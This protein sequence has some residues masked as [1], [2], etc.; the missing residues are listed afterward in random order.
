MKLKKRVALSLAAAFSLLVILL[1]IFFWL[2]LQPTSSSE[3]KIFVINKGERL[4]SIA[5][6]L[7]KEG[8]IRNKYV[9]LAL[10]Y[11]LG[12]DKKI[13]AGS[14]RLSPAHSSTE[15]ARLLTVGR[16]DK[17]L[18]VIE[19]W[20][21][22]QIAQAVEK[23]F[24]TISAEEF[25]RETK[26]MEGY[27]FPDSYLIPVNASVS[28]V[29][30]LMR[31]NFEKKTKEWLKKTSAD[32]TPEEVVILASLIEREVKFDSD[33]ALVAGVLINRLKNGWPLQV[34]ATVQYAKANVICGLKPARCQNW[35]PPVSKED[36]SLDSP[37]NTYLRKG[38][39]PTPISNPSLS[40][41]KAVVNYKKTDYWFYLSD[42]EGRIHF[43]KTLEE[44]QRNIRRYLK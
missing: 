25:L 6:R 41:I 44:H 28:V 42:K 2:S 3:E 11:Y 27:L 26:G 18:V 8:L 9:F 37:Y 13:Q 1:T 14:F 7:E 23:E 19:G 33:R 32:L 40:S 22:E 38:L 29:V 4:T 36:L 16:L 5:S 15:I 17:W 21:R 24:P 43:A 10:V 12:L 20:R 34:D 39:P 35:W 30:E 31:E